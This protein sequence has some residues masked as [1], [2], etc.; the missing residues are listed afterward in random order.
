MALIFGTLSFIILFAT[1]M[2]LA[3]FLYPPIYTDHKTGKEHTEMASGQILFA[4]IVATIGSIF[5]LVFIF[6]YLKKIKKN[7]KLLTSPY[8]F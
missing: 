3:C 7:K 2:Y 6:Q 8:I 1:T 5:T 4:L